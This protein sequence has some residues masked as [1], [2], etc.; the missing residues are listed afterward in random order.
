M[1]GTRASVLIVAWSLLYEVFF[2]AIVA[3]LILARSVGI[4][5][6]VE[7]I[8]LR[9]GSAFIHKHAPNLLRGPCAL[10]SWGFCY[11]S[12]MDLLRLCIFR[13]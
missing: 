6:I 4:A 3:L 2:Y 5:A 12:E 13:R 9:A 1:G 10:R 7:L 11:L 8:A